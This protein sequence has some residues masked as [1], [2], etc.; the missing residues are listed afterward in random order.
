MDLTDFFLPLLRNN[1]ANI[2][3]ITILQLINLNIGPKHAE[4]TLLMFLVAM[5][6]TPYFAV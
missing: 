5:N 4:H 2:H 6:I 1:I 3:T